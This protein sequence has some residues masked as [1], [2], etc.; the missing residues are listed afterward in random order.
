MRRLLRHARIPITAKLLIVFLVLAVLPMS[1]VATYILRASLEE[2]RGQVEVNLRHDLSIMV[3][4]KEAFLAQ[5]RKDLEL[6]AENRYLLAFQALPFSEESTRTHL[7]VFESFLEEFANNRGSVYQIRLLDRAAGELL[8]IQW[9]DEGC[10]ATPIERGKYRG[11]YYFNLLRNAEEGESWLLPVELQAHGIQGEVVPAVSV[12]EPIFLEGRLQSLLIINYFAEAFFGGLEGSLETRETGAIFVAS[13]EGHYLY[14]SRYKDRWGVLLHRDPEANLPDD[15]GEEIARRISEQEQ[16]I[17]E[18]HGR[19][20]IFTSFLPGYPDPDKTYKLVATLPKAAV[21]ARVNGLRGVFLTAI[22]AGILLA[23][24]LAYTLSRQ[25]S[26]PIGIL[27]DG[28]RRM[29]TG[30]LSTR[31]DIAT[32]D[33]I[34][35]LADQFN[36]M[37]AE[38]QTR[39][40]SLRK[41]KD[42]LADQVAERTRELADQQQ[43]LEKLLA[44]LPSAVVLCDSE[45][46]L[47]WASH[48][49]S[50]KYPFIDGVV[51]GASSRALFPGER[52]CWSHYLNLGAEERGLARETLRWEILGDETRILEYRYLPMAI[53]GHSDGLLLILDDITERTRI[54]EQIVRTERLSAVGEVSAA[55]A[56]EIRNS[57]TALKVMM[58]MAESAQ[59]EE[60]EEIGM[61]LDS[62]SRMEAMASN[63][64]NLAS[65]AS[66]ALQLTKPDEMVEQL[67]RIVGPSAEKAGLRLQVHCMEDLSEIELDAGLVREALVNLVLNAIQACEPGAAVILSISERRLEEAKTIYFPGGPSLASLEGRKGAQPTAPYQRQYPEGSRFLWIIVSDPGAGI[68]EEQLGRIFEPFFTTK[69]KGTGLGLSNVRRTV[70]AH[71]GFLEVESRPGKGTLFQIGL[72][73]D[74]Q[75]G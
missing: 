12:I 46:R 64:L 55:V 37:S 73:Y 70:Q 56:H 10:V 25:F 42:R 65:P 4:R 6:L 72:P 44:S 31:I 51:A 60:E 17:V 40:R 74:R 48:G 14:H 24:I 27:A 63:L 30:D 61:V 50:D 57:L 3:E 32:G 23:S 5:S 18:Y 43:L 11:R 62:V 8:R 20:F 67:H 68:S 28:A 54:Q 13:H 75:L 22:A 45:G 58:Q 66:L 2:I 39:D 19:F 7:S 26:R 47:L 59:A 52:D 1:L 71:E 9:H 33:E 69:E 38:I 36:L 49:L 16:G 15:Y 35:D 41:Q 29:G 21:L 34:S 53:E